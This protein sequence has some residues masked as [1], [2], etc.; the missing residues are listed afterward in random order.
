M[1]KCFDNLEALVTAAQKGSQE[2]QLEL[3]K[4]FDPLF[5]KYAWLLQDEDA[6]QELTLEFLIMIRNWDL[7]KMSHCQDGSM[8]YYISR[9]I[10]NQYIA[11]SKGCKLQLRSTALSSFTD[12]AVH[13]M[14]YEYRTSDCYD[15]LFLDDIK[16]YLND[17]EYE[18]IV[19]HYI[20]GLSIAELAA[21]FGTS[22]QAINQCK[23]RGLA[24]LKEKMR[25]QL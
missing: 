25:S 7:T 24:K 13:E 6:L 21:K 1:L 19:L 12:A 17:R 10:R 2:A 18:I 5:K 9:S 4:R 3:L 23:N 22:R 8:V 11:L 15:Q 16:Q 14:E 20:A